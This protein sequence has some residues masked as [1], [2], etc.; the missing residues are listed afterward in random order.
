MT[1]PLAGQRLDR[2]A[3]ELTALPRRRVRALAEG[4]M[5][6]V[7]GRAVRVLS[8]PLR[9]GDVL[10]VIGSDEAFAQPRPLPPELAILF[11][12]GWLVA[13]DKP[14]G[15]ASQP[16]RER[17]PRELAADERLLLQLA[18]RD[19]RRCQIALVHRL[20]RITT[21]VLLFSRHH[22]AARALS[23]AWA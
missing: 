9:S 14:A 6:W 20:D 7:N 8:R 22:E 11:E 12:D 10:D 3:A 15:V 17:L 1:S 21:G 18:M 5:L 4:G 16:P 23:A 2:A 19:G 13:V